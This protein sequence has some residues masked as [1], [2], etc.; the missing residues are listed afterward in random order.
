MSITNSYLQACSQKIGEKGYLTHAE[1]KEQLKH[2]TRNDTTEL[3]L[4][5]DIHGSL[6]LAE[7]TDCFASDETKEVQNLLVNTYHFHAKK[8]NAQKRLARVGEA[9]EKVHNAATYSEFLK[10]HRNFLK[11]YHSAA[12]AVS[13]MKIPEQPLSHDMRA[14]SNL[15]AQLQAAFRQVKQ[16]C[17][18]LADKYPVPSGH[19]TDI[20]RYRQL[21]PGMNDHFYYALCILEQQNPGAPVEQPRETREGRPPR[22]DNRFDSRGDTRFDSP[23]VYA[24]TEP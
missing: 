18:H 19:E 22:R 12:W 20:S 2:L 3:K 5:V 4:F 10:A 21:L 14:Y 13:L 17:L 24:K 15:R 7:H 11:K 23:R 1:A 8:T 6:A 9:A 16:D